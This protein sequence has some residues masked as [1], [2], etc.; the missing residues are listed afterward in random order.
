[1]YGYVWYELDGTP[2]ASFTRVCNRCGHE[3]DTRQFHSETQGLHRDH[4][5][6]CFECI[7]EMMD[8]IRVTKEPLREMSCMR[9]QKVKPREE[10]PKNRNF[11][12]LEGRIDRDGLHYYCKECMKGYTRGK[13]Q[14]TYNVVNPS[15]V[16]KVCSKCGVEKGVGAFHRNKRRPDGFQAYCKECRRG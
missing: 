1:M 4:F 5:G 7:Q 11:D 15:K 3:K 6:V 16:S 13:S 8:A 9:C 10:F 2:R 12:G 14:T